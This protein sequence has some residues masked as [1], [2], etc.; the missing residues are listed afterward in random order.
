M[1]VAELHRV[2]PTPRWAASHFSIP[3][4]GHRSG[5]PAG[6]GKRPSHSPQ[7]SAF[8]GISTQFWPRNQVWHV[9][10]GL[11]L[12]CGAAGGWGRGVELYKIWSQ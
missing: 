5:N 10:E 12:K 3:A 8:S 11:A 6:L 4:P 1:W 7:G 2:L 9:F